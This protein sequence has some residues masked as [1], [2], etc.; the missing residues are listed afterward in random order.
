M[1]EERHSEASA[2]PPV[3]G[4]GRAGGAEQPPSRRLPRVDP[5]G[6]VL[7]AGSVA[8]F[9]LHGFQARIS[10]DVAVYAYAGQQVAEGVPPYETIL[11]RAGPLAHLVPGAGAYV[12]RLV[13]SES[14][15]AMRVTMMVVSVL[16][17]WAAYVLGRALFGSRASGA[18]AAAT[19]LSFQGFVT[20]ATA[21]PRE[22][23]VLVLFLVLALTATTRRRWAR[24]G[25][26]TAL[27]TLTWQGSF[28]PLAAG[29][30]LAIALLRGR[31]PRLA[32]LL[33]WAGGGLA[34]AAA[35]LVYFVAVGALP[36]FWEGFYVVNA[37]WTYQQGLVETLS[38]D[39]QRLFT[40]Y[41]WSVWLLVGGLLALLVVAAV[42]LRRPD[43]DATGDVGVLAVAAGALGVVLWSMQS[44][45]G[46]PDAFVALPYAACGVAGLVSLLLAR[47]PRAA[48]A[49][50]TTVLVS[51]ALVA[52]AAWATTDRDDG[53]L[54]QRRHTDEVLAVLDGDVDLLAVGNPEPLVLSGVRNPIRYQLFS[55]GTGNYLEDTY[56]GGLAGLAGR[57]ERLQP[58]VITVRQLPQHSW[59]EGVLKRG[60]KRVGGEQRGYNWFVSTSRTTERQRAL[61][62]QAAH[63]TL[64]GRGRADVQRSLP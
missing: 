27:A 18:V 22:K 64:P 9:L 10:R 41:G 3:E 33:R 37:G 28:F 1:G 21:G 54:D 40:G 29:A 8:V 24:A 6:P 55:G 44:F 31:R 42:R 57:I 59:L 5:L 2:D 43:R 16:A 4:V 52:S 20:Y 38:A 12:G 61:M 14:L 48:A 47:L 58:T 46:W 25:A 34:V 23:T 50:S 62:R 53:L 36:A 17:V 26:M 39:Q 56:P 60:Y 63:E 15:L 19:L 13:G 35:A 7:A 49:S 51:A 32:A 45:E 11:N 30:L